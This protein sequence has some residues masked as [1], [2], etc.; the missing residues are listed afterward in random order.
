[1]A[2]ERP[3]LTFISPLKYDIGKIIPWMTE[4]AS[5]YDILSSSYASMIKQLP[6]E[7]TFRI[8]TERYRPD[9]IS[10]K[11]YG[12]VT[13]KIPLMLY[14]DIILPQECYVGRILQYPSVLNL[15]NL[16]FSL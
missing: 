3:N 11:I 1:M 7:G 9:L 12:K 4:N 10:Y 15:D 2:L 8:V 5:M 16:L 13:Y 14:N 6:S